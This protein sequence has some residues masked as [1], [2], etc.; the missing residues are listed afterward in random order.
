MPRSPQSNWFDIAMQG[1]MLGIEMSMVIAMR[2]ARI[3]GGGAIGQ[4]ESERMIAEKI[5]ANWLFALGLTTGA[6]GTTPESISRGAIDHYGRRV[7][8]NRQRLSKV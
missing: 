4:R 8:A 1:W 6:M 2:T 5:N 3:M 7:R